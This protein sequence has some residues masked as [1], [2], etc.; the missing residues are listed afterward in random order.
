MRRRDFA[1]IALA[2]AMVIVVCAAS[3]SLAVDYRWALA[4]GAG[5]QTAFIKNKD[6]AAL[7]VS[8]ADPGQLSI[9]LESHLLKAGKTDLQIVVKDESFP[10]LVTGRTDGAGVAQLDGRTDKN[11]LIS[12]AEALKKATGE[13]FTVEL[14]ATQAEISFSALD[15][16]KWLPRLVQDCLNWSAPRPA[17]L[18]Q[19]CQTLDSQAAPKF[20]YLLCADGLYDRKVKG[21]LIEIKD[22]KALFPVAQITNQG[23]KMGAVKIPDQYPFSFVTVGTSKALAW[24]NEDGFLLFSYTYSAEFT[25]IYIVAPNLVDQSGRSVNTLV[26]K[27]G[28]QWREGTQTCEMKYI[29]T[30]LG[31]QNYALAEKGRI[32]AFVIT[33]DGS[34]AR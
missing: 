34:K 24:A 32:A 7:R 3:S 8:C 15:A 30:N 13:H 5:G 2:A 23:F 28:C 21:L 12:F 31:D 33:F 14:P 6:G 18:S 19:S 29:K 9:D 26:P 22:G 25:E 16:K 17:K 4:T 20:R 11:N 1:A 10:F 27:R